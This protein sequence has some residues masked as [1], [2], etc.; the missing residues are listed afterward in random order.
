MKPERV[1]I[2]WT[3]NVDLPDWSVRRLRA[4]IDTGARTC[5]LHVENIE[6]LSRD[7]VRFDIVLHRD[8][9]DRT[10][11]VVAP[12]RRRSRVRSSNGH[13]ET[14]DF[15]RTLLRLGGVEREVEMSLVDRGRM[16]HRML[17]GRS[18]LG[19]PFVIDASRRM[20]QSPKKKGAKKKVRTAAGKVRR[21]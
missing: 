6:E 12:V 7:R 2:G 15:V 3:E 14:R 20:V 9:R 4:K 5:A 18:A 21:A 11:H 8:K 17:L 16:I 13:S 1:L 10:V 19:P